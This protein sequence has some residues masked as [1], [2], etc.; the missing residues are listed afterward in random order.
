MNTDPHHHIEVTATMGN[1]TNIW[2]LDIIKDS[3]LI[4]KY[5]ITA[6]GIVSNFRGLNAG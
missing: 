1:I 3:F 2:L 4:I 5:Y 6:G